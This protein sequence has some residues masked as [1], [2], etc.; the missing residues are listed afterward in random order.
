MA[1]EDGKIGVQYTHNQSSIDDLAPAIAQGYAERR[2][3]AIVYLIFDTYV[4]QF[5]TRSYF[6]PQIL[7]MNE[8]LQQLLHTCAFH[9]CGQQLLLPL[10]QFD[11]RRLHCNV[12]P[13]SS[14]EGGSLALQDTLKGKFHNMKFPFKP[15]YVSD[16][17]RS[18]DSR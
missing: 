9:Y 5:E 15:P 13:R 1:L 2:G 8:N 3:M 17:L 12:P 14:D 10:I 6:L 7:G 11:I 4:N 18:V 16:G